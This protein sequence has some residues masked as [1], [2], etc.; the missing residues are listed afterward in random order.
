[1]S[2][3]DSREGSREKSHPGGDCIRWIDA[4][5]GSD[6]R[7]RAP[8]IRALENKARL[9]C[10]VWG[11]RSPST[12]SQ[13]KVRLCEILYRTRW[14]EAVPVLLEQLN[15]TDPS[16]RAIAADAL[17]AIRDVSAGPALLSLF[18]DPS[19]PTYV[20]DTAAFALGM[21]GYHPAWSALADHLR[22]PEETIRYCVAKALGFL[23]EPLAL[24]ALKQALLEETAG[25]VREQISE[26]IAAIRA[27]PTPDGT[28]HP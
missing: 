10:L 1:M 12:P 14:A 21:V 25:R 16:V 2:H 27:R 9:P 7:R 4:I 28:W 18:Q 8:A 22:D 6:G 13:A 3:A 24:P 15:A 19:Q 17:G 20:R 11:L 26:A 5:G 23:S